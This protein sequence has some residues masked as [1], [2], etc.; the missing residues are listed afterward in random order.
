M[1]I[2]PTH[3]PIDFAKAVLSDNHP[4]HSVSQTINQR[5]SV[6]SYNGRLSVEV[7]SKGISTRIDLDNA[8]KYAQDIIE[9]VAFARQVEVKLEELN[10]EK[11]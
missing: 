7:H 3:T 1:N 6:S 4:A 10:N 2:K 9:A 5:T 8:E 11:S